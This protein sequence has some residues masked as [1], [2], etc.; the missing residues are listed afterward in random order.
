MED[1]HLALDWL[2]LAMFVAVTALIVAMYMATAARGAPAS[3]PRFR[4]FW[5]LYWG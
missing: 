3:P 5:R 4:H 2:A 1:T